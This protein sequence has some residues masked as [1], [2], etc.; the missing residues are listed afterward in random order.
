MPGPLV[1]IFHQPPRDG[2]PP[3]TH[4]LAEARQRLVAGQVRLFAAAG[5]GRVLVVPGREGGSVETFGERLVRLVRD[6]RVREGLIVL[7]S[8]AVPLLHLA[9]A[10]LLVEA[11]GAGG[12][13]T[14]TNNRYSSDVCAVS[15]AAALLDLPRLPSDNALP[16]WLEE[17]AGFRVGELRARDRL[18]IDLDTPLDLALLALVRDAPRSLREL[19]AAEH[20][21]VPRRDE[22]RA[23]A[24]DPRRE[25]LVF[26]RSGSRTLQWLER[27]VRCR[28]RFLAEERGLRAASALAI[29]ANDGATSAEVSAAA[30]SQSWL[31]GEAK[32][33]SSS[34][35]ATRVSRN[36]REC[37]LGCGR[38]SGFRPASLSR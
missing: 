28:V 29:G 2:D 36:A 30:R 20:V 33:A 15:D 26:G 5:A 31:P 6:E 7:G 19:A 24:A 11:A 22:L 3:L 10:R 34:P 14:L 25:L 23:L 12:R 21:S 17:R 37:T 1:A 16:R 35:C 9:E 4:V 38:I 8:G 13:V 27:N 18:A 32:A